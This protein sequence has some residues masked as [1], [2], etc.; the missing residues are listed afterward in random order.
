MKGFEYSRVL[1][2]IAVF[3][4]LAG[5]V[6]AQSDD[7]EGIPVVGAPGPSTVQV[8][9]TGSLTT[10]FVGGNGFAGNTFDIENIGADPITINGW[11]V[12]LNVP[13]STNTIEIYW[14]AG[15]SVGFENSSAGWTQLGSDAAVTSAGENNPSAVT[16]PSFTI[17][18]GELF[19]FYV[20]LANYGSGTSIRYTNGGPTVFSNTEISLTTYVGKGNPAFTGSTFSYRQWNGTVYYDI[21]PVELQSFSVE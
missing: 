16:M 21:V 1:L 11:D 3:A 7:I 6:W 14:R 2:A 17:Q 9:Q 12:N 4:L 13:G 15:T 18:T 5:P 10:S 20:D 19:G 8:D